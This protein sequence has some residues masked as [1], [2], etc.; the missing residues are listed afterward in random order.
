MSEINPSEPSGTGRTP[1]LAQSHAE[2][3]RVILAAVG[4]G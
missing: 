3:G 1:E 2:S 4:K